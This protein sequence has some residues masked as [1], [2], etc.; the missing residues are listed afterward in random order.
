VR[1]AI[2]GAGVAG[3]G[4][5]WSLARA[6]VETHVFDAGAAGSGATWASAGMLTP[7]QY[8]RPEPLQR[9]CVESMMLWPGYRE[10]L[11]A[12]SGIDIGYTQHGAIRIATNDIEA[13]GLKARSTRL[14]GLGARARALDPLPPFFAPYVRMAIHFEDEGAVDNRKLGPALAK[15][16]RSAGGELHEGERIVRILIASGK[17]LGVETP[18]RRM[19]CDI[20]IVA[21]GAWSGN[22]EGL[23]PETKPPVTPR[24]GQMLAVDSRG[25]AAFGGPLCAAQ[26]YY[27]VP[28]PNGHVVVGAT[29]ED[30][31]Y[32]AQTNREAIQTMRTWLNDVVIG[33]DEWPV[34][35]TWAGLRPGTPD[36]APILGATVIEGLHVATGQFRDGILLCPWIADWVGAGVMSGG[37]QE[38]LKPFSI[39]RFHGAPTA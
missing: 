25:R 29:L 9:A 1:V 38:R 18:D 16:V 23:P 11:E 31:G 14:Q 28:R 27:A 30:T 35:E 33:A 37:M 32:S 3:L 8:E 7:W 6:G 20:A 21:A 15:A 19:P 39:A 26:G 36:D 13:Q 12:A 34:V 24:K 17:V 2:I 10:R 4:V 22:I 5:A